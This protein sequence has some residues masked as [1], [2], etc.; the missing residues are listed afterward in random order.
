MSKSDTKR[1]HPKV[2]EACD[3]ME[4]GR[5]SRR[6]FVRIAALLGV[7]AGTAYTMAGLPMPAYAQDGELPFPADDPNAV[8]GGT[9]RVAM[10]VQ[11]MDDPATYS[12][13]Q[14]SNQSRHILEYLVLTD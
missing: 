3:L 2:R 9:L 12:W 11:K 8:E 14:M 13:T 4:R 10:Q 7:A 5:M 6:E 1:L